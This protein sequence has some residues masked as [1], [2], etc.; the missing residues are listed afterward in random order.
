MNK[1]IKR[2]LAL[3]TF[4]LSLSMAQASDRPENEVIVNRPP[5]TLVNR[6]DETVTIKL[7]NDNGLNETFIL[8]AK[9]AG[10]DKTEVVINT[11]LDEKFRYATLDVI[12]GGKHLVDYFI[13]T[14][15]H[16]AI[17]AWGDK[18]FVDL[19]ADETPE[20]KE[21]PFFALYA[22]KQLLNG[23]TLLDLTKE[24]TL[25][26]W[27]SCT[28][29]Q[30][31]ALR[32]SEYVDLTCDF[33]SCLHAYGWETFIP[34]DVNILRPEQYYALTAQLEQDRGLEDD[35]KAAEKELIA[36]GLPLY[37]HE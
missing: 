3:C 9:P 30:Q 7:T 6:S 29:E 17:N 8:A 37:Q 14:S 1:I 35:F 18:C 16:V 11:L 21:A 28:P 13:D 19:E 10:S 22:A 12:I 2:I 5:L 31:E 23:K 20:G 26:I 27:R 24:K 15:A 25:G 4:A 36:L 34:R 33:P 32:K